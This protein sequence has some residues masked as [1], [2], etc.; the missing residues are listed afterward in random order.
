MHAL[1]YGLAHSNRKRRVADW[2]RV[3]SFVRRT[4]QGLQQFLDIVV[5]ETRGK[6]QRAGVYN[7]GRVR[8]FP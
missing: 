6:P 4:L 3:R 7:E 8:S 1:V 5:A 2:R